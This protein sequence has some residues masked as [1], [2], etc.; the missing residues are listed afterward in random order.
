MIVNNIDSF[1]IPEG[2]ELIPLEYTIESLETGDRDASFEPTKEDGGVLSI[3]GEHFSARGDWKLENPRWISTEM[4]ENLNQG[5]IEEGDTLLV[6]DGATIGK[7]TYVES[8]PDEKAATNSHVYVLK[9]GSKIHPKLLA[10]N[11]RSTW[12]QNQIELFIR[13]SAQAGL[14]SIFSNGVSL[15]V[16][17]K[18]IQPLIVKYIENQIESIDSI[19]R[20]KEKLMEI[21][22]EKEQSLIASAVTRGFSENTLLKNSGIQ[23]FGDIPA[24][25]DVVPNKAVFSEV[26]DE[27]EDG[28]GD[29][30][31]VSEKTGVSLKSEMTVNM[32]EAD[33]LEG[34]KIAQKDDLVINTM[35]AWKGAAG[36]APQRGLVSPSYHVYRMNDLMLPEFADILYRSPPYVAEMNR[37]SQGVWK[38]RNRLYPDVFLRMDTIV[39]PK[40]EQQKIVNRLNEELEN[41]HRLSSQL[42]KSSKLLEEK[43]EAIITKA[44]TGRIDIER[45]QSER[46]EVKT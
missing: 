11:L 40:E 14:P 7:T 8:V 32:F 28:K 13:G 24:H 30:L 38:S 16:P 3:G 25:W 44:V 20:K 35:W 27:S 5:K 22:S 36:I 41:I 1:E 10:Y 12:V 23:T 45:I 6:K 31:S 26:K 4:Y 42:K 2:W 21:L 17:P 39:P 43:R 29:L 46:Q 34:Y 9:P 19:I 37:F 15:A 33:S 18:D